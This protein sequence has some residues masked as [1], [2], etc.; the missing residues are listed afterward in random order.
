MTLIQS[1][2]NGAVIEAEREV[3]K[4]KSRPSE[5]GVP[6]NSAAAIVVNVRFHPD[7][8]VW[9]INERPSADVDAQVWFDHLCRS[10]GQKYRALSGGRGCFQFSAEEI[11]QARE[12]L[13]S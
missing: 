6:Q 1:A 8:L 11:V 10:Y 2:Q 9:Q 7:G 3:L 12:T 13:A 5:A 4:G